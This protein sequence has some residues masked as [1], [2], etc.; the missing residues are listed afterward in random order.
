MVNTFDYRYAKGTQ[1]NLIFTPELY[2][3]SKI[4]I[5][6]IVRDVR[7]MFFYFKPGNV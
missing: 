2:L 1:C 4:N 7:T 6:E 3:E 5:Y